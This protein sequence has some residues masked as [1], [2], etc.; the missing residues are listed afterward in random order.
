MAPDNIEILNLQAHCMRC[1]AKD[2]LGIE[3][4]VVRYEE[5][6]KL[7]RTHVLTNFNFGLFW[8]GMK[9]YQKALYYFNIAYQQTESDPKIGYNIGMCHLRLG[10]T[11]LAMGFF[12]RA[13]SGP[14]PYL[15]A[16]L[17]QAALLR[18]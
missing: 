7:D 18:K 9:R 14:D 4:V 11:S 13:G 15:E 1:L 3:R 2:E 12:E 5:V 6:L 17:N 10:Q 16:Q 8:F